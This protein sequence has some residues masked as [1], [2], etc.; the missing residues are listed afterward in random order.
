MDSLCNKMYQSTSEDKWFKFGYAVTEVTDK[1]QS[2]NLYIQGVILNITKVYSPAHMYYV[3]VQIRCD[4]QRPMN[5][6]IMNK[7]KLH[8]TSAL[9]SHLH[10]DQIVSSLITCK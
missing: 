2:A 9:G 8:S 6:F 5:S 7:V 10:N 4:V 3:H 1:L